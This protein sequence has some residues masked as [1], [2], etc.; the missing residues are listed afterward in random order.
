MDLEN[1]LFKN[2]KD[3]TEDKYN[4]GHNLLYFSKNILKKVMNILKS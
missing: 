4:N 3:L 1:S 2:K